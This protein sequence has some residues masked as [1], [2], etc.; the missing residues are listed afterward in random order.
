MYAQY[1]QYVYFVQKVNH[2]ICAGDL[3]HTHYI[4]NVGD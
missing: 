1:V 4:Q 2:M 3:E